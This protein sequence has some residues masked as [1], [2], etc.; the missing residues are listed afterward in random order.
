VIYQNPGPVDDE[1]QTRAE[2]YASRLYRNAMQIQA[3]KEKR[4]QELEQREMDSI[5][6]GRQE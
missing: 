6:K 5:E 4:K 2:K 1:G 3:R